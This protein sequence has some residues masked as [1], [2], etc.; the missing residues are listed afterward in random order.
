M[1]ENVY[2]SET[3]CPVCENKIVVAK[4]KSKGLSVIKRDSDYCTHYDG[5]NPLYYDVWVCNFCGYAEQGTKFEN[6][7]KI[8]I[9]N[10][11][12]RITPFWNKRSYARVRTWED[13]IT[14]FKL[15]LYN[16]EVRDEIDSNI[17]KICLRIAWLYRFEN[18]DLEQ[19]YLKI[20]NFYYRNTY[21]REEFPIGNMD[22]AT[23]LYMI[24]ETY[25]RIN[26]YE[27]SVKW[28]GY[29]LS[30]PEAKENKKMVN[31]GR[32]QL[33]ITREEMKKEKKDKLQE[34]DI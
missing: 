13:A 33:Q 26:E 22:I 3:Y 31:Q 25:R 15:A 4:I 10:I 21:E 27:D 5:T 7:T 30:N 23:C 28:F 32:E 34:S 12:E 29:L 11:K 17:A 19:Q 1:Q 24:A 6:A 18:N 2:L 8:Q 9:K 14:C 16:Y 20:T